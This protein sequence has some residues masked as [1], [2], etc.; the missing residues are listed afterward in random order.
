MIGAKTATGYV[1][2]V[3]DDEPNRRLLE[4]I[5]AA[6][7]HEVRGAASGEEALSLVDERVPDAVLLDLLMPGVPGLE[8]LRRLRERPSCGIMPVLI[9]TGVSDRDT[10]LE[11]IAAGA[12]DF[13]V[14]PLDPLDVRLRIRNAV[15]V[16]RLHDEVAENLT[17]LRDLE[18]LRDG[19]IHMVVHDMRS[20]LTVI[21]GSLQF[22]SLR[23]G[24]PAD[25]PEARMLVNAERSTRWLRM[26]VDNLL[27]LSRLEAGAMPVKLSP[28][29]L[30]EVVAGAVEAMGVLRQG[31]DVSLTRAPAPVAVVCDGSLIHRVAVNLLSNALRYTDPGGRIEVR[32]SGSAAEARFEVC[33]TGP[34]IAPQFHGVIFE[35]FGQVG[36]REQRTS[37]TTGLGLAFCKLAVKAHGGDIGV[38]SD[39]GR[40]STFWVTMPR[41]QDEGST[42]LPDS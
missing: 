2:V 7:G 30:N 6:D 13:L 11:G 24:F 22:L 21:D 25:T 37:A 10:R 29:D 1:L 35:K 28:C 42:R 36:A 23:T 39:V 34:G 15:A 20:P 31:I 4:K 41:S 40:G 19:L 33:D 26:M 38:A 3:D 9:V 27:D 14:K 8:V 12:N 16:K 32:V 5:L 17:R 18:H